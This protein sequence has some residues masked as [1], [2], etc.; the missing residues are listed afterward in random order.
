MAA[1]ASAAVGGAGQ[2]ATVTAE[3]SERRGERSG[4][5]RSSQAK[6]TIGTSANR[7]SMDVDEKSPPSTRNA[8]LRAATELD[9]DG[10]ANLAG[11]GNAPGPISVSSLRPQNHHSV[12]VVSV[13]KKKTSKNVAPISP[14]SPDVLRAYAEEGRGE[15]NYVV[16]WT[17]NTPLHIPEDTEG[18]ELLASDEVQVCSTLRLLPMMYL[19]IKETL[20]SAR[21][22]RGTF[23]KRDAQ[24]WCRVDVNKTG[25]IY[26]WFLSKGWLV[27]PPPRKGSSGSVGLGSSGADE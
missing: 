25:K 24:S 16:T 11:S 12:V 21:H 20:L 3:K 23:R 22:H 7:E 4:S 19:T 10:S 8:P 1:S 15:G 9:E 27:S 26:D 2:S 6:L 13:D 14:V 18:Y 17:K 5:R